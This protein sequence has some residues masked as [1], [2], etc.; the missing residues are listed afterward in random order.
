MAGWARATVAGDPVY[1]RSG[2][3]RRVAWASAGT[4]YT[5]V[6]EAPDELVDRAVQS[7]PR[8]N[9]GESMLHRARRG[10]AKMGSW[11]PG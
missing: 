8:T 10:L 5:I 7:F 6:A 4:V 2:L 11:L 1:S 9:A 3:T